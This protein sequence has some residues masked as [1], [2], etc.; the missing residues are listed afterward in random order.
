MPNLYK[1]FSGDYIAMRNELMENGASPKTLAQA[2]AQFI[3]E[4]K[5]AQMEEL[6]DSLISMEY[7]ELKKRGELE[8]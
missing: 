6:A 2:S 5:T 4:E 7:R 8:A 3:E 1:Q